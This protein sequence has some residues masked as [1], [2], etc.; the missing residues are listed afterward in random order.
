MWQ[1]ICNFRLRKKKT[2]HCGPMTSTYLHCLQCSRMQ[3]NTGGYCNISQADEHPEQAGIQ[4]ILP[5]NSTSNVKINW[6]SIGQTQED[7]FFGVRSSVTL[8]RCL[9]PCN[10]YLSGLKLGLTLCFQSHLSLS[11]PGDLHKEHHAGPVIRLTEDNM[12]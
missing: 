4:T 2:P 9:E 7:A 1:P 6:H 11:H 5:A 8:S 3:P 12:G 10:K